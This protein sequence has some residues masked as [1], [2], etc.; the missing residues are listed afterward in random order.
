M[1][2]F[3]HNAKNLTYK[4]I[5]ND[6]TVAKYIGN[7]YTFMIMAGE[8]ATFRRNLF[9][10]NAFKV[11]NM[12]RGIKPPSIK[13]ENY[14]QNNPPPDIEFSLY[15]AVLDIVWYSDNINET[16]PFIITDFNSATANAVDLLSG[17][18]FTFSDM[19]HG[20]FSLWPFNF[21]LG[22]AKIGYYTD[23]KDA[24]PNKAIAK[25]AQT[26]LDYKH[27]DEL[28]CLYPFDIKQ[29]TDVET[30]ALKY[31]RANEEKYRVFTEAVVNN[32]FGLIA[33]VVVGDQ[34][35]TAEELNSEYEV[36]P[37]SQ[38]HS[39]IERALA[40]LTLNKAYAGS[41]SLF[42][43]QHFLYHNAKPE[44]GARYYAAKSEYNAKAKE[45]LT[46]LAAEFKQ[47]NASYFD[48]E[49]SNSIRLKTLTAVLAHICTCVLI[50]VLANVGISTVFCS[51]SYSGGMLQHKPGDI[52]D[53]T[54]P[55]DNEVYD[56]TL[57]LNR[58]LD[59]CTMVVFIN[60]PMPQSMA[61][62]YPGVK[63]AY[64]KSDKKWTE[65]RDQLEPFAEVGKCNVF[66][67]PVRAFFDT[68]IFN[69]VY[70]TDINQK[71]DWK[72][73][74]LINTS[75]DYKTTFNLSG[76]ISL[77]PLAFYAYTDVLTLK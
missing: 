15:R 62:F 65:L 30:K 51:T 16:K 67:V 6:N 38:V 39:I 46:P 74:Y 57:A 73:G 37:Y 45:D 8:A 13:P 55:E 10:W 76:D 41:N 12:L 68:Y 53:D 44:A 36:L 7:Y 59:W 23:E 28:M 22:H 43:L 47:L 63:F 2:Y 18:D 14:D 61:Q 31:L 69:V 34:E 77:M 19:K 17:D 50:D 20:S 70:E 32:V 58:F 5:K 9:G 35:Y 42:E 24:N 21:T 66:Y 11:H 26:L 27:R 40:T 60:Q 4:D 49:Y 75:T 1:A 29:P 48:D 52:V 3:W 25:M 54:N 72:L 71:Y 64:D 33:S 56:D